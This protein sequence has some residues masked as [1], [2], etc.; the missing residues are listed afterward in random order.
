[1]TAVTLPFL[2]LYS[3]ILGER[4][5]REGEENI[6]AIGLVS[7]PGTVSSSTFLSVLFLH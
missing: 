1:M 5:E 6:R 7:K 4:V 2:S 3:G